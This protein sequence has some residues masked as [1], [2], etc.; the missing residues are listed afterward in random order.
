M[1][2]LVI[3]QHTTSKIALMILINNYFFLLSNK[4]IC[5]LEYCKLKYYSSCIKTQLQLNG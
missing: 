3:N 2:K 1:R 5:L 4:C